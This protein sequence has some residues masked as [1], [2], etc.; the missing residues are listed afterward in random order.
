[1]LKITNI[2]T[3]AAVEDIYSKSNVIG[4]CPDESYVQK[5]ITKLHKY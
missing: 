4:I 2:A 1:M 5:W 3:M